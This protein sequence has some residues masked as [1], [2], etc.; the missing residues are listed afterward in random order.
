MELRKNYLLIDSRDR[1][2]NKY[3]DPNKYIYYIHDTIKNIFSVKLVYALYPKHGVEFYTN[4]FI[5]EFSP[6]AIS[7]N[8]FLRDAFTQLP[9][10]NYFNEYNADI[11]NGIG[12][13][14][15]KPIS[16]LNK[17]SIEFLNYD[18]ENSI[19]GDHL[20]KFEIQYYVY[21]GIIDSNQ[22]TKIS[23]ILD[24]STNYNKND[25]KKAY[26]AKRSMLNDSNFI[27]INKLKAEYFRLCNFLE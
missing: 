12:K 18:G 8:R 17:L 9:L 13:T 21:D 26:K 23:D 16:K 2:T 14:F 10:P 22:L 6:N 19:M 4:L 27:E 3:P 5:E 25:L 15:S 11:S 1:D 7:S 24:V 20:L